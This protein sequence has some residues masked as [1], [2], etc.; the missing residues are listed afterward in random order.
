MQPKKIFCDINS[1]LAFA[2]SGGCLLES[3]EQD[4]I[5]HDEA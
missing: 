1:L 3:M 5:S 2:P 4:G